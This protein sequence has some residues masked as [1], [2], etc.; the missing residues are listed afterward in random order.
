MAASGESTKALFAFST[1][2]I[3]TVG[4]INRLRSPLSFFEPEAEFLVT[5]DFSATRL[6]KNFSAKDSKDPQLM[7][8][9]E[10]VA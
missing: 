5:V 9:R 6:L 1:I 4:Q 8:S 7:F 10:A 3:M 2:E